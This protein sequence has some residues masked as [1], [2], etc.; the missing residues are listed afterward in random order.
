MKKNEFIGSLKRNS[1]PM[2]D[3]MVGG[4]FVLVMLIL[5]LY[6]F[7]DTAIT[8]DVPCWTDENAYCKN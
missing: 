5:M 3:K 2:N 8:H 1:K 7:V 4:I 6:S